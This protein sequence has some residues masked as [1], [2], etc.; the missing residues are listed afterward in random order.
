[1]T[2]LKIP[3][4]GEASGLTCWARL[5]DEH[6]ITTRDLAACGAPVQHHLPYLRLDS[7]ENI[8]RCIEALKKVLYKRR[9]GSV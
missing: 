4:I 2:D 7:Y 3:S 8:G 9:C 5:R 6:G 1:M